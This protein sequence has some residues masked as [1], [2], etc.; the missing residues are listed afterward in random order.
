MRRP[1]LW[2]ALAVAAV[3]AG[4]AGV[5][6]AQASRLAFTLGVSPD[7]DVISLAE[8]HVACQGPI[9]VAVPFEAV[10][11]V[12]GEADGEEK[13]E[14]AVEVRSFPDGRRLGAG[15]LRDGYAEE[16][17]AEV[18]VGPVPEGGRASVCLRA[19]GAG[20][21]LLYGGPPRATRTSVASLDGVTRRS[22]LTLVFLRGEPRSVLSL[23]PDMLDRAAL[24]RPGAPSGA[25]LVVLMASAALGVPLLLGR[26]LA[27]AC[28]PGDASGGAGSGSSGEGGGSLSGD[29]PG[30]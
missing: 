6:G 13:P 11:F 20:E 22:D 28:E 26:A 25:L 3:L 15:K 21:V 12:V 19:V 2:L 29:S 5:A 7:Q 1:A 30:A 9:D 27:R 18:R 10:R 24:W 14:V 8:G 4:V 16:S 17:F 23:V